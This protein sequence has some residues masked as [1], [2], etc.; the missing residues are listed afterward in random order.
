MKKLGITLLVVLAGCAGIEPAPTANVAVA[1]SCVTGRPEKPEFRTDA[2]IL[3]LDDYRAVLAIRS[4][5]LK[6]AKYIG[7][8]EDIVDVCERAP[9]VVTV[10][11]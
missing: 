4:E 10:P 2:E 1:V 5:R 6:A 9:S 7:E 11:R 3:A 8:L